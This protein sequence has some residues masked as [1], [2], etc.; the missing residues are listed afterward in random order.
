MP[1]VSSPYV[2]ETDGAVSMLSSIGRT[3]E[4]SMAVVGSD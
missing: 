3:T 4:E 2:L 1:S